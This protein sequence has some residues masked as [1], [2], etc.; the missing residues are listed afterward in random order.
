MAI[1]DGYDAELPNLKLELTHR[2]GKIWTVHRLDKMTSGVILFAKNESAHR[3]LTEQ[4]SQHSISKH[5]QAVVHGLPVWER[6]F[7]RI[8]FKINGDRM[9]RTVRD[10]RYG[11]PAITTFK[12]IEKFE[13]ITFLDV[14][15]QTGLTHQIRAHASI[16]GFPIVG[17]TLYWHCDKRSTSMFMHI[18]ILMG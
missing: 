12:V 6:K 3:D 7:V 5:Y 4:F 13:R 9:H 11:K 8:P 10:P 16:L 14:F 1:Q 17:D 15:P 18:H 2:Y